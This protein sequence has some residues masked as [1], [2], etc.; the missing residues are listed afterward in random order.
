MRGQVRHKMVQGASRVLARRGLHATAFSEVL[1][2]TGASRG[3]IYHH[4]PGGKAEL[5]EAVL[6]D[7]GGRTDDAL[8]A[9]QGQPLLSV[10]RGALALWRAR[11]V[12]EDCG[13]GCPVAAVAL[14]ADSPRL[15]SDCRAIFDDWIATLSGALFAGGLKSS[16][17]AK[18]LATL[19]MA[20]MEGG[21]VLARAQGS[22]EPYDVMARQVLAYAEHAVA[23]NAATTG[24]RAA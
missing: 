5:I 10:V 17:G 18:A 9:L 2:V 20:S 3:S 11:L 8:Q 19:V 14:A 4:F 15:E 6:E 13:A 1:A 16:D 24:R 23:A 12:E 22:I 7:Y 21:T